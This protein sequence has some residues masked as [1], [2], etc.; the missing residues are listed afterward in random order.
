MARPD[1]VSSMEVFGACV[2]AG[3]VDVAPAMAAELLAEARGL[4]QGGEGVRP[5]G[6]AVTVTDLLS[7]WRP[8]GG[9]LHRCLERY[10]L[11]PCL[12]HLSTGRSEVL[13]RQHSLGL[14]TPQQHGA[15]ALRAQHQA[16]AAWPEASELTASTVVAQVAYRL[17]ALT[18]RGRLSGFRRGPG[19]LLTVDVEH[20]RS[21]HAERQALLDL[22][23]LGSAKGAVR[24]FVTHTPC[25]SCLSACFQYRALHPEVRLAVCATVRPA[26]EKAPGGQSSWWAPSVGRPAPGPSGPLRRHEGSA[27]GCCLDRFGRFSSRKPMTGA[28]NHV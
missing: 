26:P 17:E 13:W 4:F 22:M 23:R 9:D 27:S 12:R 6:L 2:A 28:G 19:R 14:L 18:C 8:L 21:G 5:Y 20:A 10:V 25:I 3:H 24:L 15:W 7:R 16:L 1:A 11:R